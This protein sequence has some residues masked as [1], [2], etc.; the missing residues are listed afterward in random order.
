[1][2]YLDLDAIR[3]RSDDY[4]NIDSRAT[5]AAIGFL[6][7]L[8]ASDVPDLLDEVERLRAELEES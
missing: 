4:L 2:T 7:V 5:P 3:Q 6:A 1:M 8:T